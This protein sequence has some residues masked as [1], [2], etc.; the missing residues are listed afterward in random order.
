MIAIIGGSILNWLIFS[1]IYLICLPSYLKILTL[2]V[3]IVGGFSGYLI[4]NVNL[5]FFNKSLNYYL[6]RFINK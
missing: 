5:Y 2:F 4:R 3:C 6:F 1:S